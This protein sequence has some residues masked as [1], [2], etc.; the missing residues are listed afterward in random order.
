MIDGQRKLV[1]KECVLVS[2]AAVGVMRRAAGLAV[3][4]QT[5]RGWI[6]AVA[7]DGHCYCWGGDFG[8]NRGRYPKNSSA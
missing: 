8:R 6:A 3:R 2:N 4:R 7:S 5:W 1:A